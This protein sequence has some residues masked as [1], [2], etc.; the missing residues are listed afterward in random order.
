MQVLSRSTVFEYPNTDPYDRGNRYG[1]SHAPSV[2]RLSDG[3]LMAAW[4]SG[5]FEASVHQVILASF[6]TD[7]GRTWSQAEVMQGTPRK[8]DFDPA[9][10]ATE[11]GMVPFFGGAMESASLCAGREGECG[12]EVVPHLRA[13]QRRWWADVGRA[14]GIGGGSAGV[15]VSE[16]RSSAD[17]RRAAAADTWVRTE[18]GGG[19]VVGRRWRDDRGARRG[20]DDLRR[21]SE[22][23]GIPIR[24]R[25][26]ALFR[27]RRCFSQT[28][29]RRV[30]HCR[31]AGR[32]CAWSV[33][34]FA[35]IRAIREPIATPPEVLATSA[36]SD[37]RASPHGHAKQVPASRP[38][39]CAQGLQSTRTR[40]QGNLHC[41]AQRSTVAHRQPAELLSSRPCL[42]EV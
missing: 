2:T 5:P 21:P 37:M 41:R 42:T 31:P 29:R 3:R 8:S 30:C 26:R 33:A 22:R 18:C 38:T 10:I 28:P 14:A 39:V 32:Q 40:V 9:F 11:K 27:E 6:S 4:F 7:E 34:E 17:R 1:F 25:P 23:E 16:Q 13:I 36:T 24:P 19:S 20:A 15:W 12:A 35:R